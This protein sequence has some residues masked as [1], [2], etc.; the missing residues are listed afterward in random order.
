MRDR[1][2]SKLAQWAVER[3][4]IMLLIIVLLTLILGA[5]AARI[6][7]TP[8]WSDMLPAGDKRTIEFDRIL[9]EFQSASSIV[10]V[11][12]G[13]E[14]RIKAFAD[15]LAP[16][17]MHPLTIPGKDKPAQLYVRRVDYKVDLDFMQKHGFMLMKEADLKNLKDIFQEPGLVGLLTNMNNS[18]EKEFIQPEEPISTRASEDNALVFLNG[19]ESWLGALEQTLKT[20]AITQTAAT[21][22]VDKLI[23]GEP[24]FLSYDRQALILN[25]MP[26]FSMMDTYLMIDGTDA[27]QG[28]VDGLLAEYPD[29]QAGLSGS[30]PLGRD[31]M[32]S[33]TQGLEVSTIA[34]LFLIGALLFVAF[35]MW[36][37]PL[38]ALLNLIIGL[39]W[40]AGLVALV[41]PLL[42]IMTAMFL[43]IL[44]GL[45]I[46]FSIHII[47]AFTEMRAQ[48][49]SPADAIKQGLAKSGKGVSTG[50][51]TT[52]IAFLALMIGDSRAMSEMGLVTAIGL[53][54]VMI[55]TFVALPT[56]LVM[57][58]RG[59]ERRQAK[60][61]LPVKSRQTDISFNLM[62][63]AASVLQNHPWWTLTAAVL[64]TIGLTI[65]AKEITFNYNYMD[66]EPKDIPSIALQDTVMD[67]FDL[68]MD[69]AYL[70]AESVSETRE[71]NQQAKQLPSVASV[72]DISS[73]LPSP[74]QQRQRKP[75]IQ[76]IHQLMSQAEAS[77]LS[78]ADLARIQAE[79][80][81]LEMN[82]MEFQSMAFIG[83][84]D[85]VLKRCTEIVG[86][87]EAP[88][89]DTIF[90]RLYALLARDQ[91]QLVT[92]LNTFQD[93]YV[94]YFTQSVM[95]MAD[96]SE[97]T[98]QSLPVSIVDRY[99][100]HDRT[101]FL[102]TVLP[103]GSIWQNVK[104]LDEFTDDLDTISD[105]S[106]GMPPVFRALMD[107]VAQDGRH[108]AL[109]TLVLI[110]LLLL[111]DFRN[112]G[113]AL[114]AMI[115]LASGM[116]WMVGL[117][118]L[119]HLQLDVV[120]VM[121]LPLILGIGIDDGVHVLHRW[122]IE[123]AL[124]S[125]RVFASTGKAVLLTSL[126][127]ML[128]FGSM[129]FSAYRGYA[130]LSYALIIGVGACFLTTV[131]ILPALI[132][133]VDHRKKG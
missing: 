10:V 117:M 58:E 71:L 82:I 51:T 125:Y 5:L 127:T 109:L 70:V 47:A 130:S 4:R 68:S 46:D 1:I 59:K 91:D 105:R 33:G 86:S 88:P 19:I 24:Y 133:I 111:I 32:V 38:L 75:Y 63:R 106:T 14:A 78:Q 119:F 43:V 18:F 40:A 104:F 12:Q 50:A 94:D 27:V 49:A 124:S 81:R 48:G 39:V 108:A 126:T 61:G 56:F 54:A 110:Y 3:T 53:I 25:V 67:K 74:T 92:R 35:R 107:I 113:Y 116:L 21:A 131:V 17:L 89:E 129:V 79:L 37:A 57:R 16:R 90:L 55:A 98:L 101:L 28:V 26:T 6:G 15:D 62:G 29:V 114:M 72:D 64:I 128:A 42:N 60:K 34:S 115:P 7:M 30:I 23:L 22:A 122:R 100:N 20:G 112:F 8:K 83:G 102:T 73:Y 87:M 96:T 52:A 9:N 121:A 13:P 84:Q 36:V 66:M 76:E 120:N 31:E 41:V 93:S 103:T 80:Q 123:G 85:K 77:P 118:H 97:I 44:L 11:V 69:F 132:G 95:T 2:I 99:A 45:G 65:S